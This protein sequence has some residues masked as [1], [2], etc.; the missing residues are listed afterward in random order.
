MNPGH[1]TRKTGPYTVTALH[2]G[3]LAAPPGAV[4]LGITPEEAE[5]LLAARFRGPGLLLHINAYLIQGEGRTILI[6]TGAGPNMG[7]TAGRMMP[8]L[9]AAGVLPS[10]VDTILLTHFHGDHSGGLVAADGMAIFPR[11]EL[12]YAPEEAA[13]WF[14][15]ANA[16]AAP[17]AKRG[18]FAAAKAAAAPYRERMRAIGEDAAPGIT[19]GP[20]PGH[21]PGHSGYQVG[22][23]LL[24]WGDIMHVPDIQAP[25]PTVGVGFDVDPALA[26]KTREDILAKAASERLLVAG[27]HMHFPGF[28]HVTKAAEG[29]ALV[30]EAWSPGA[31]TSGH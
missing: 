10:D 30:P 17:E 11:A 15:D 29:Y 13:F 31:Y 7:P 3:T 25:R 12:L 16:A 20:L 6:D 5:A 19:R 26:I 2:D 23:E 18:A 28:T 1:Y 14:D 24:I 22:G 27:M 21:T 9:A 8:N 4:L